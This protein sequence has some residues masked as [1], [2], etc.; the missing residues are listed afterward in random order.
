MATTRTNTLTVCRASAGTGKTYTLAATYVA[1]L[2]SGESYRSILAVTFTNKATQEMKD[3]ILLFLDNIARNTGEDANNALK[4][5]RAYMIRN[6]SLSDEQLREMAGRLYRAILED[7][8]NMHISTID[9]FLMQLL[10]GLGQMLDNA[11]AGARVELNLDQVISKAVDNLLSKPLDE[12]ESRTRRLSR[13][14]TDKLEDGHSWDVRG[15]LKTIAKNMYN[16]SVQQMDSEGEIV[17]DSE[18]IIRY[19][20]A[21]DYRAAQCYKDLEDRYKQWKHWTPESDGVK[22]L[23]TLGKFIVEVGT[24]LDQTC[25]EENMFRGGSDGVYALLAGKDAEKM[26]EKYARNPARGAIV[27]KALLEIYQLCKACQ[28]LYLTQKATKELLGD[29]ALMSDLRNEICAVL[30]EEN[31]ILLAQTAAKLQNAMRQGD[32]DFILEKVGIRY[33]HIMLDE[34][35]DTSVLQWDNFKPLLQEILANGGTVF[36]VG[37]IKQSIYRWRNGDWRIMH[38]LGPQTPYLGYFFQ[39]KSLNRNFRSQKQ[40]VEFNGQLFAELERRG[41]IK[42]IDNSSYAPSNNGGYVQMQLVPYEDKE[43]FRPKRDD[44][45]TFILTQVFQTIAS[46]LSQGEKPSEMLILVKTHNEAQ[47]V[48]DFY[49]RFAQAHETLNNVALVSCDSFKLET[50]ISVLT[51]IHSLRWLFKQ[52]EVSRAFLYMVHPVFPMG[53]LEQLDT[54]T[55]L[56]ELLEE[57]T[58]LVLPSQP[59]DLAYIN[60]LLDN[61]HDFVSTCN[62]DVNEFLEYWDDTLHV[63]SIAASQVDAIRIM[64]IHSAKGLE[65]QNVFI[66]FC[67]WKLESDKGYLWCNAKG[68]RNQQ[69]EPLKKIP[70]N[71][72]ENLLKSEYEEE[73][74][75]EHEFQHTDNINALYVALTRPRKNLYIYGAYKEKNI[76][77]E[78]NVASLLYSVYNGQW[79]ELDNTDFLSFE[80]A[81]ESVKSNP[82]GNKPNASGKMIDRFSFADS[83]TQQAELHVGERPISFQLSRESMDSLRYGVQEGEESFSRIDLGNVCHGIMEHIE[84]RQDEEQAITEAQ[85]SGLIP[86]EKTL[87]QVR[88]LIDG[89]WENEQLSDWFSGKWELLREVTFLTDKREMRPDRVMIDKDSSTAIVLDYKFGQHHDTKYPLQVRD[90]MRIMAQLGYQHVEGYLWFAQDKELQ[91]VKQQ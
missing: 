35:Q 21:L 47:D 13:Y 34:F 70:L 3:R 58:K 63:L 18:K 14:V 69:V 82:S 84:T 41:Y 53:A 12:S 86:D 24:Y 55:P 87:Q 36:I 19:R 5:V 15:A 40:I 22:G 33:N 67:D 61:A 45:K 2:L 91:K 74:T 8:D 77:K 66:P 48:V 60:C 62:T 11:T 17:F 76:D 88:N 4:A 90:Y 51:L 49:R 83:S 79:T 38:C 30:H 65:A 50:S 81:S 32:A 59:H 44:A 85:M 10:N 31:L 75:E 6:K 73:I 27:R 25:K 1:L 29:L 54:H 57:I 20:N 89:A 56:C 26:G 7:Y 9:T 46:R 64:T 23:A 80:S 71:I 42:D 43:Q 78:D 72:K 28:R 16:E 68:M 52:D 37:D 39:D